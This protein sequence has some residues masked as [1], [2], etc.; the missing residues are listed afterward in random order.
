LVCDKHIGFL[1]AGIDFKSFLQVV[2]LRNTSLLLL[3]VFTTTTAVPFMITLLPIFTI[4]ELGWNSVF[5][6]KIFSTYDLI[7][8]VIGMAVCGLIRNAGIVI[9]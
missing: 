3:A 6:S 2:L 8:G 5:Y 4:Q 7:G 9:H 1:I